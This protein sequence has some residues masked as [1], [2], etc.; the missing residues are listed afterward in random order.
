MQG[1]TLILVV[2]YERLKTL[3]GT[4]QLQRIVSGH[5]MQGFTSYRNWLDC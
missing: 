1:N 2:E 5:D 3:V 4:D